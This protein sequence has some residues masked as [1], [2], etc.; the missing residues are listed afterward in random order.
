MTDSS[1]SFPCGLR[2]FLRTQNSAGDLHFVDFPFG[3]SAMTDSYNVIFL[4]VKDAEDKLLASFHLDNFNFILPLDPEVL[5]A[6]N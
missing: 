5:L 6:K 1:S 3:R 4:L 2:V